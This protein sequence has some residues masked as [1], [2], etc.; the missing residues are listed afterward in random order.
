MLW[1][2]RFGGTYR[3]HLQGSH[4]LT[5]VPRSRIF[6]LWRWRRYIPPNH[7]CENLKSYIVFLYVEATH[8]H[9]RR[10]E[11]PWRWRWYVPPNHR[12]ENLKSYI[13]FLYVD[14][15]HRHIRR[16]ETP[17]RWRRYVPPNHRCENLKSYIV[18]L[19]VEATHRHI[20]RLETPWRWRRYVPPKRRFTQDLHGT[21]SQK[22]AFPLKLGYK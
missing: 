2:R 20:R 9:I 7:R 5:L 8:R 12:S 3:L 19:H 17:W 22:T 15:T 4:L 6:L 16:L 18:F 21:T 13:V 1:N 14:A 11:K 10:L